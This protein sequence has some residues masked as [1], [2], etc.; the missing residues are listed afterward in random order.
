MIITVVIVVIVAALAGIFLL[1]SNDSLK[2]KG[3][4]TTK[5]FMKL[6]SSAFTNN[7]MIPSK[8]TCDGENINPPISID[9]VP[10]DAKE[11]VIV[12]DDPD[13]PAGVWTHWTM[14][15]ITPDTKDIAENSVPVGAKEGTTSF[16]D[17]GYGGPCPPEGTGTHR[18]FF[19]VYALDKTLEL[20]EGANLNE[21][22]NEISTGVIDRAEIIGLY[23]HR[24]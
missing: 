11:L 18:Y 13:A 3:V 23:T 4:Q 15:S 14:W 7:E 9:G 22:E 12:V 1:K 24:K 5:G 17:S 16:G 19:K 8:Y 21:L 10:D 6:T 2:H 20:T